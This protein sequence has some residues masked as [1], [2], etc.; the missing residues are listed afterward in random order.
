MDELRKFPPSFFV[1]FLIMISWGMVCNAIIRQRIKKL[2]EKPTADF[3]IN[4][5]LGRYDSTVRYFKI[6]RRIHLAFMIVFPAVVLVY[7]YL[8]RSSNGN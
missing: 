2:G 4:F 8:Y 3:Q 6:I 1:F 5:L 7:Y